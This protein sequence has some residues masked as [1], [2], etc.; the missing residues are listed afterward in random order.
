MLRLH[1]LI[2]VLLF[3]FAVH[4]HLLGATLVAEYRLDACLW[5]GSAGEVHDAILGDNNGTRTGTDVITTTYRQK[6]CRSA[7]FNG[8]GIDID[9]LD[10]N[11]TTGAKNS[12][13]FWMYWDGTSGVMPFGWYAHDLWFT[14]NAFG[15]NS[16]NSDVYGISSG[17]LASGWHHVAAIFTN[18]D[19][20]ANTLYIDGIEQNLTQIYGTP[21]NARSVANSSARIGGCRV[22]E[23]YRFRGYLDEVRIY[24]GEI[25]ASAVATIMHAAHPCQCLEP[26]GSWRLD[27]CLWDGTAGEVQD[28]SG[29]A[30]H[31]TAQLGATT[32]SAADAGGGQCRTGVLSNQYIAVPTFPH[33]TQ[34]RS[35]TAWF[36]TTDIS[37]EGQR[38]FADDEY[39]NAGSY[40][41]SVGDPGAGQVRFYIR[42]LSV[43][44]LDSAAVIQ[45]NQWYFAAAT[46]DAATMKKR[47]RI[48]DSSGTLLSDVHATVTGTLFA[49]SGTPSLGGE[50]HNG[51]TANR[52]EGNID[53][54]KVY[55]GV[56][57]STQIHAMMQIS[58][59]CG[60]ATNIAAYALDSCLWDG[61]IGEIKDAVLGDNNGTR[62]GENVVTTATEAHLCRSALFYG[63]VIDIDNLDVDTGLRAKNSVAFWMYWD[64]TSGVM[65][66]G[67]YAHDLWFTRGAFGFNSFR[68]DIYGISSSGLANGWHHVAA[69]FTNND[70]HDNTLYIDG[71]EQN[72][73]QIYSA[74]Y[75][76][77]SVASSSARIGGCR[78]SEGYRFRGYLDE[79]YI[80]KGALKSVEVRK[81]MMA[82]HPCQSCG[83]VHPNAHFDVWDTFRSIHDR[84]ISTK[85]S[86]APFSLTLAALNETN[87]DF[88][89]FNG[90][91]CTQ[92]VDSDHADAARSSWIKS[93]FSDTNTTLIATSSAH[94]VK[95]SRVHIMWKRN[96]DEA[97]PLVGEDNATDSSD[98]FAIR[99]ERFNLRASAAPYYASEPFTLQATAQTPDGTNTLDYNETQ[100]GSFAIDA[101]ETRTDCI[102]PG[103]SFTIAGSTFSNGQTT[104]IN[105]SFNGLASYLNVKIHEINGSE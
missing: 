92:I 94:A 3:S 1:P 55:D 71:V 97:C 7:L 44:S 45:N 23:K 37:K 33:L 72:L 87:D 68:S 5:N 85:R 47:L 30:Y 27:E 10:V 101:N 67:W 75:N 104:D 54:V 98:N 32:Q 89:E 57:D 31:G 64:G 25:N 35:I 95:N 102:T 16:F 62:T 48:F 19:I 93:L 59:P 56:L 13:T 18:G 91:V 26:L 49:Q 63:D 74:P 42:G 86:E 70:M 82:T 51:E 46:F 20:H 99:P 4:T 90:T 80:F 8:D 60:C 69:I 39:N 103:E 24:N 12:V 84:N 6:V 40:A 100:G 96:V 77:R 58:H 79:F 2:L 17:G 81:L 65:P 73:T 15:F 52:F 22:N 66:F 14:G 78:V 36:K 88:Q 50:T 38:I 34:S 9:N 11:T 61:S 29:N 28:S 83:L 41:L 76:A 43:V 21:S 105:A 53:E